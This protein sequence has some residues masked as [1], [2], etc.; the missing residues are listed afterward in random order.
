MSYYA[1]ALTPYDLMHFGIKG[2]HWHQRRYQNYDGTLT[3]AGK[4]RYRASGKEMAAYAI[5]KAKTA[6]QIAGE[7]AKRKVNELRDSEEVKRKVEYAKGRAKVIA[8]HTAEN[9]KFTA[10]S[11]KR[12]AKAA[13]DEYAPKAKQAVNRAK[14]KAK[15]TGTLAA[16]NVKM[17]AGLAKQ[18]AMRTA[19]SAKM[20]A[21]NTYN[22][23]APKAKQAANRAAMVARQKASSAASSA[24]K[25][26]AKAAVNAIDAFDTMRASRKAGSAY[27]TAAAS[28]FDNGLSRYS[29]ANLARAAKAANPTPVSR[30]NRRRANRNNAY[31][32]SKYF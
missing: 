9:A 14:A 2:Q 27:G 30:A 17:S 4:Q 3:V 6:A 32:K 18:R 1:V 15:L 19:S 31:G 10:D 13:Y 5:H 21:R 28:R 23:Y 11:Y 25:Y 16:E 26:G 8:R 24:R 22:E 7:R 12:K 20:R 29:D